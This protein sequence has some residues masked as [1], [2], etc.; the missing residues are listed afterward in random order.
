VPV[1]IADMTTA[2]VPGAFSLVDLVANAIMNV[3]T[4]DAGRA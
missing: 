4:Q 2:H 1:T 3:T